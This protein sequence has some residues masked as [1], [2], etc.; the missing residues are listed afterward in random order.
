MRSER[1]TFAIRIAFSA[2]AALL[3]LAGASLNASG[4]GGAE[5]AVAAIAGFMAVV[6]G[7]AYP[8]WTVAGPMAAGSLLVALLSVRFD[9]TNPGLP[10]QLAG[11][12]LLGLGGF[13]GVTAYRSFTDALRTKL[14][15]MEVLNSQLQDK[16]RAFIAATSDV[17]GAPLPADASA[18]TVQLAHHLAATFACCYLVGPDGTHFVPQPPGIGLGRLHPQ[19]VARGGDKAGPLI[20]AIDSG[21]DFV[22]PDRSGLAELVNYV[23]DEVQVEGLLAVPMLI[24]DRVGGFILLGNRPGGFNDDDRRLAMTLIRRAGSQLASAHAVAL[25]QKESARYTLMGQLVKDASG[26]T[27]EE[28]LALVLDRVR[29]VIQYDSGRMVLFQPDGTYT[30]M[31]GK[32]ASA[33][34]T[35]PLL[36]V[37]AGETVIRNQAQADG[38]LLSG[39]KA[40]ETAF[41]VNEALV[42]I[43]G[44]SGVMGA[45]CLG[46]SGSGGFDQRDAVALADLGAMAGVAVENSRILEAVTGQASKLDTALDAL[47]EISQALTTVTQGAQVLEQK[48][49]EAATR[50]T[51]AAAALLTRTTPSGTQGVLRSMG[52]PDDLNSMEFTNG[53]GIVGAVMLSQTVTALVDTS[54]SFDLSSPPDLK[55]FGLRSALCT[56]MLEDGRLWGTLTV[57]DVKKRD[58]TPDDQRVL[59]TLGNQGVVA[60]RNAELYDNNQRSIWELKNLQEALQAATSTLDLTQVLQQVLAG[61]A[62]ASTAQIGCL[63]LEDSGKLILKAGFGTDAKTAEKLALGLGGDICRR[64]MATSQPFMETMEP[65][66]GGDNPLNPRAVLCVAIT[67][68]GTPTGVLFLANYQVGRAFTD[69]HRNLVTE[70]AAQAAVAIDNARLFLDREEVILSALEALAN[71]VDARDPYTAGHSQRVTQYAL[72][73]ARQM[74][75][76]PKDQGAWVRLERGV[77]LHDIGKIGVPDAV[78]QKPGKLTDDE[79]AKMKEHPVVGFNILSGLKML[80]DELVIVRS[81]HERYDGKGYPD[82]KKSDELPIFAW[83]ASAA[84]AIDAMTS[85]RPYRKGMSIEVAIDQVRHGAGT[86][87]HPDVAEAVLD[88]AHNGTLKVIPQESMYAN[89]PAIGAFE[90]PTT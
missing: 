42:P 37:Q 60:V 39:V 9:F 10:V 56:P 3:I 45:I 68:R 15:E 77:R 40:G 13:V 43:R 24:G 28:V 20:S 53:Q 86:Q 85:D 55:S 17:D 51:G 69:D 50:V 47:G 12:V 8:E 6:A 34:M 80:T 22:A 72:M 70:L 88:A 57:F 25:S 61:A 23:P 26:K 38:E 59:A 14:E 90:N 63:A 18:L 87:F 78:L 46:R 66:A 83:I 71:A 44:G 82:R 21:R 73:I 54:T 84:D 52:F 62:K 5:L 75:Y 1:A 29:Q 74:K 30:F 27:M 7:A 49:L 76:S 65:K 89:A 67:L 11:L 16:E 58:W 79:F 48:T 19:P 41:T 4:R 33:P 35:G 31:D 81:H 36:K 32:G 64:V 2:V